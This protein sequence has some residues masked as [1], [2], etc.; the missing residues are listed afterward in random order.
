VTAAEAV[1]AAAVAAAAAATATAK[2]V[3]ARSVLAAREGRRGG[4]GC[5]SQAQAIPCTRGPF[6]LHFNCEGGGGRPELATSL[7]AKL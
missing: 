6:S 5:G 1:A 4:V 7:A 2:V 3:K